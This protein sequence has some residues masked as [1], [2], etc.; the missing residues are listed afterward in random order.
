MTGE[1]A[2]ILFENDA[3]ITVQPLADMPLQTFAGDNSQNGIPTKRLPQGDF[4]PV[5]DFLARLAFRRVFQFVDQ[6]LRAASLAKFACEIIRLDPFPQS[7]MLITQQR[8]KVDGNVESVRKNL[9]GSQRRIAVGG[10]QGF[11]AQTCKQG[12]RSL[13]LMLA[14][15]R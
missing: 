14:F 15:F 10:V 12:D 5:T 1:L 8:T 9:C 11:E 4:D 13:D 6:S 7:Q 2:A 3:G